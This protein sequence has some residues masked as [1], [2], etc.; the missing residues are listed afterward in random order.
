VF[1]L[2]GR[3]AA[4]LSNLGLRTDR[5]TSPR[6][7]VE[8]TDPRDVL[9]DQSHSDADPNRTLVMIGKGSPS[10]GNSGGSSPVRAITNQ[11]DE[12]LELSWVEQMLQN[13]RQMSEAIQRLSECMC[14]LDRRVNGLEGQQL[15]DCPTLSDNEGSRQS[16][17]ASGSR[18][19]RVRSVIIQPT[20]TKVNVQ[21]KQPVEQMRQSETMASKSE[22][23]EDEEEVWSTQSASP[24]RGHLSRSQS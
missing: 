18:P 5:E 4:P 2:Q 22:V 17:P 9:D 16:T 24:E 7:D 8:H 21:G 11:P 19:P 23:S 10:R 6:V 13:Q 12:E 15:R 14:G 1:G 3:R 20:V